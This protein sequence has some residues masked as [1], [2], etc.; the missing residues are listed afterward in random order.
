MSDFIV[1]CIGKISEL[2]CSDNPYFSDGLFSSFRENKLIGYCR[3]DNT[4]FFS[5]IISFTLQEIAAGSS[6]PTQDKVRSII[7]NV[8]QN[9]SGFQNKDGL[10]T[11]NFWKTKPSQHFPNGYLFKRSLHYKIPDDID[12]TAF[13][14]LLANPNDSKNK[15]LK[16]KLVQHANGT[17]QW[18][19]NTFHDCRELK[20]YSTWFGDKMYIEFDAC[21]LSNILYWVYSS[22][23]PLNQNDTDSLIYIK[24]IIETDR[25]LNQPFY[26]AHHYTKTPL[27]IYHVSR[28][29]GAFDPEILRPIKQKLIR[30]TQDL[31]EN[32][33]VSMDKVLLAI[34]LL[35]L[36]ER[37]QYIAVE[38]FGRNEFDQFYFF[39]AGL[40]TAYEHKLIYKM[41]QNPIF[42]MN[43]KCEAHCWLLLA[44]Y[45]FLYHQKLD[46]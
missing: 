17:T 34:S 45:H 6:K 38:D 21:A 2:Q 44:E 33:A 42:H 28:L 5:A 11:Y 12:D 4:L 41:A 19:K 30:D 40:L 8:A 20:A 23:L 10:P 7:N 24:T 39:I 36:G 35:R 16:A 31:L 46:N 26:C 14:Y 18:I 27:I 15:W 13:V 32:S 37:P 9:F 22:K 29:I 3:P 25:Y 1:S 43:W